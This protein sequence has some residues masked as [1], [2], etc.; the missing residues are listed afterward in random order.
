[1]SKLKIGRWD[2]GYPRKIYFTKYKHSHLATKKIRKILYFASQI[3]WEG[4]INN[5][6][7]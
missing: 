6:I 2:D 1:M 7:K 3:K 4:Y 5:K